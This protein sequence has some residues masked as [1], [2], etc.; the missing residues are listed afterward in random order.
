MPRPALPQPVHPQILLGRRQHHPFDRP[1]VPGGEVIERVGLVLVVLGPEHV[2]DVDLELQVVGPHV[3]PDQPPRP[4]LARALVPAV[5][6]RTA[7]DDRRPVLHRQQPD[8]FVRAR[9]PA[10]EGDEQPLVARVLVGDERDGLARVEQ[11][12]ELVHSAELVEQLEPAALA[13]PPHPA[14]E[15]GDVERAVERVDAHADEGERVAHRL[16]VAGVPGDEDDGVLPGD[17]FERGPDVA[18]LDVPGPGVLAEH[19]GQKRDLDSQ[20]RQVLVAAQRD[21]TPPRF[22]RAGHR[23]RQALRRPVDPFFVERERAERPAQPARGLE[24]GGGARDLREH[25]GGPQPGVGGV[26][27][28]AR[29]G[30]SGVPAEGRARRRGRGHA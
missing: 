1:A 30:L 23:H 14:V 5:P 6:V 16:P 18:E 29:A 17:L 26:P 8:G 21:V 24:R 7:A 27:E 4:V 20:H 13:R 3:P 9:Q 12:R 22:V 10:E 11:A 25:H 28:R 15:R 2:V 19:P